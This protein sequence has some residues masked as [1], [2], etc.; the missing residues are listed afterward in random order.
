MEKTYLLDR[1]IIGLGACVEWNS[2]EI[3]REPAHI[4]DDE[5]IDAGIVQLAG[6]S[7]R[8]GQVFIV[9]ECVERGVNAYV[10]KVRV[11]A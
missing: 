6:D 2:R 7:L 8:V 11:V 9:E 5:S 4:L 3:Q 1:S 10:E